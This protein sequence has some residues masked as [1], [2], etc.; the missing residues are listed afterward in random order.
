MAAVGLAVAAIPEGLPAILTITLAIGVRAHGAPQRHHP[1][2]A[3]GRDAG[4]GHGHLLRQDR[5]PDP[6]RD[7]RAGVATAQHVFE[8]SGV[9][10]D[11]HGG[12]TLAGAGRWSRSS[13]PL[14]AEMVR[15]GVLC[16]EAT[17]RRADGDGRWVVDGDPMEGALV[18]VGAQG[19]PGAGPRARAR[20]RA[21][22][23]IPFESEHRFMATLHHD[24]EGR[25][26]I[27][28]KGAPERVLAMCVRERAGDGDRPLERPTG[29]GASR[30]WRRAASGCWRSPA[31]TTATDHRDLRFDDVEG[32]LDPARPVR[33]S[34]T[35]RATRRS[36]PSPPAGRP[37]SGSR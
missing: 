20:I 15:A 11:P 37:A 2:P 4:L 27:Y 12:F 34:S 29:I 26:F 6:E 31:G 13:R 23:V 22:D 19:R 24:H 7:D 21:R 18:A 10:Y 35:R 36:R 16:N 25:G 30:S 28:V 33:A 32:G 1:P 3:G 17:L 14:L 9:G 5:N 8:V